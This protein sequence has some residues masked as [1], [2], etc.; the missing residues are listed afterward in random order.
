MKFGKRLRL[1]TRVKHPKI[2]N[3]HPNHQSCSIQNP[4]AKGCSDISQPY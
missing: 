3:D 4:F 1:C 2:E